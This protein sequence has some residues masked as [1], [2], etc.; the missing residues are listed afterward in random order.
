MD[1]DAGVVWIGLGELD[2]DLE[3]A[4]V[5]ENAG[6]KELELRLIARRAV[7]ARDDLV[8]G[9]GPLRVHV[10]IVHPRVRRG[11]VVVKVALLHI[12]AVIAFAVGEPEKPLLNDGVVAVP[13]A[14]AQHRSCWSSENPAMPS[15]PHL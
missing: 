1:A 7:V 10:H 4:V 12:L 6:I 9:V 2:E 15:S 5:I 13:D 3:I 8:V 11:A 14:S